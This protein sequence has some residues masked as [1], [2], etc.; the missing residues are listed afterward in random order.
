MVQPLAGE[1]V[2]HRCVFV[3]LSI[4]LEYG[5]EFSALHNI[6]ELFGASSIAQVDLGQRAHHH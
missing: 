5:V 1:R 4:P 2:I 6:Y 3:D